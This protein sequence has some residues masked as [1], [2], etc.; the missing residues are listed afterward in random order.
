MVTDSSSTNPQMKTFYYYKINNSEVSFMQS[1]KA[2][3]NS[4]T[5]D[6]GVGRWILDS[7]RWTL[8]AGLWALDSGR[9]IWTLDSGC[10]TL[11]AGHWTL[12][13]EPWTLNPG[14]ECWTLDAECQTV[15]VITLK[16]KTIQSFENTG[17]ISITSFFHATLSNHVKI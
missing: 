5:L 14:A 12:D 10:W 4:W 9:W 13:S 3:R 16:F 11:D 15:D 6:A 2:N 1:C 8:D 17:A 7:G